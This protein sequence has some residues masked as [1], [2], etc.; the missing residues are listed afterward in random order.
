[1]NVNSKGTH[2]LR[3]G[4]TVIQRNPTSVF[5]PSSYYSYTAEIAD[6]ALEARIR[7]NAG[8]QNV[9]FPE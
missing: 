9:A 8:W 3:N 7:A 2:L 5:D 6:A 4:A 1:M